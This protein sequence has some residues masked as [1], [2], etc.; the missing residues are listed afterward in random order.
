MFPQSFQLGVKMCH[1]DIIKCVHQSLVFPTILQ[2][3]LEDTLFVPVPFEL[4]GI[5]LALWISEVQKKL[6]A[7]EGSTA[8]QTLGILATTEAS[9][10]SLFSEVLTS[11]TGI[12]LGWRWTFHLRH[13]PN[14]LL[15]C[16]HL[17]TSHHDDRNQRKWH[18][19]TQTQRLVME[20][21]LCC[22]SWVS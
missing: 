17:V 2:L 21:D 18:I 16:L 5:F 19:L 1:T 20:F 10:R 6:K 3:C 12:V 8:W 11:F 9:E 14:R 13:K 15:P 4:V 7:S 22:Q